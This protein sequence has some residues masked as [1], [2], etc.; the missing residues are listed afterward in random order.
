MADVR[1]QM[2]NFLL[3]LLWGAML[4][5]LLAIKSWLSNRSGSPDER[6]RLLARL[7]V[8]IVAVFIG[9]FAFDYF[10]RQRESPAVL[11]AM[12]GA[13]GG[14]QLSAEIHWRLAVGR[15]LRRKK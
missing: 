6:I 10:Y 4:Y 15:H 5:G 12:I 14:L 11:L 3:G 2:G 13:L 7:H 1:D 9:L 8:W